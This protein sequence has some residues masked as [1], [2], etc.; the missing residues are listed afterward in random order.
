MIAVPS[1]QLDGRLKALGRSGRELDR[2]EI[3]RGQDIAVGG[4]A[5]RRQGDPVAGLEGGKKRQD[6]ARRGAGR[7]DDPRRIDADAVGVAI[8]P[9]DRL[10]Q[11]GK[12]ERLGIAERV[13]VER[14]PRRRAHGSW[15]RRSG[16]ADL[17]VQH[18]GARGRALVRVAQHVHD[19]EGRDRGAPR[20][21]QRH[22]KTRALDAIRG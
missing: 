12:A 14:A 18:V 10:A 8:M 15:R 1:Q 19:D 13:L 5:R 21:L 22:R 6:E 9:R 17:E 7:D 20:Q 11:R 16:L 2:H 4:I 3:E